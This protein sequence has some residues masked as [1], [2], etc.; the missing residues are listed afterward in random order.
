MLKALTG[1]GRFVYLDRGVDVSIGEALQSMLLPGVG[2]LD[3]RRRSYPDGP[4]APQVVGFVGVDDTGLA[5]L[6]L[7]YQ[8]LLAGRAGRQ[9]IEEDPS[10][11]VIPQGANI[12]Q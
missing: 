8:S 6:E 1:T 2:L 3:E 9:V 4:I 11:T 10:G 7:G 12:D 5:G